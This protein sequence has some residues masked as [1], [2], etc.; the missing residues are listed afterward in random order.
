VP[1]LDASREREP[2]HEHEVT[3]LE[4]SA[5]AYIVTWT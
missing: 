4:R 5:L 3:P 2:T 1:V